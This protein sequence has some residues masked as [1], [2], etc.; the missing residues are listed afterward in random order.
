MSLDIWQFN[1]GT[2]PPKREKCIFGYWL[3]IGR[4]I[5]EISL[6]FPNTT[7][8]HQWSAATHKF[9]AQENDADTATP[10]GKQPISVP[11]NS[12]KTCYV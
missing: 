7:E 12:L 6:Q 10:Q 3:G 2:G 9:Q 8:K 1:W 5:G 11:Y 4:G